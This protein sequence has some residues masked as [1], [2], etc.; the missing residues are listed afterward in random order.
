MQRV[1]INI[2]TTQS[3]QELTRCIENLKTTPDPFERK[4][5]TDEANRTQILRADAGQCE[6]LQM[7]EVL[8]AGGEY[9]QNDLESVLMKASDTIFVFKN[10]LEVRAKKLEI[11]KR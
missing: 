3:G 7:L 1:T 6:I 8:R 9:T 4:V 10:M 2:P 11:E 5:S